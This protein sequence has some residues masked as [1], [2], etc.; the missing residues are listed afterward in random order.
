MGARI[1]LAIVAL[2][3]AVAAWRDSAVAYWLG[4]GPDDAPRLLRSDPRIAL[5]ASDV[6]A[7]AQAD[8][9]EAV[10]QRVPAVARAALRATPLEPVAVRQLGFAAQALGRPDARRHLLLA[11]RISRRDVPTEVALLRQAAEAN[12][13]RPSFQYLDTILTIEP[14]AGAGFFPPMTTLL[15]DPQVRQTVAPYARRPWF[16]AFAAAALR[17]TKNPADL[18]ALLIESRAALPPAQAALLPQ[19]LARLV[20]A[21]DYRAAKDL[22]VRFGGARPAALDE[23]AM[24]AATSDPRFAPLTWRLAQ[25][26]AVQTD[27]AADGALEVAVRPGSAGPVA[28]RATRLTPGSYLIEQKVARAD[29]RGELL[30]AWELRCAGQ[31]ETRPIWQQPLP[32]RKEAVRYR[33]RL[34]VPQDCAVQRWRLTALADETQAD[35]SFRIAGLRVARAQ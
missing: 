24:T 33:S 18:A 8:A 25:S 2:A 26:D 27:L 31:G 29:D 3:V 19:L 12:A 17:E 22:A 1:L 28:E 4:V 16:G 10:W 9:G 11:D 21:G 20:D 23:F 14:S 35:T 34:D 30:V 32:L 13:Y 6:E 7:L 15:A 5:A